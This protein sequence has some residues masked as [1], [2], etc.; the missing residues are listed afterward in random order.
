MLMMTKFWDIC[1]DVGIGCI[2]INRLHRRWNWIN[3]YL[4]MCRLNSK[5]WAGGIE[6]F[7]FW[8]QKRSMKQYQNF[9]RDYISDWFRMKSEK[10]CLFDM[11]EGIW[12]KC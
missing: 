6:H 10:D 5:A 9:I 7:W 11:T 3:D 1:K 2:V 12:V 8:M 4:M